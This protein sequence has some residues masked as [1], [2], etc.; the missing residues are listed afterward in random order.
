MSVLKKLCA[1]IL[2]EC[3]VMCLIRF[4]LSH[5]KVFLEN[6]LSNRKY[7]KN[8]KISMN[9]SGELPHSV[10]LVNLSLA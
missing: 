6:G 1:H 5:I 4:I 7:D 9:I 3:G 2:A 8:E 10:Q